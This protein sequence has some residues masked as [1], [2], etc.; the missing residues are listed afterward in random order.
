MAYISKEGEKYSKEGESKNKKHWKPLLKY[1]AVILISPDQD[2]S[3]GTDGLHEQV[4][5]LFC[6]CGVFG[7]DVVQIPD[8]KERKLRITN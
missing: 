3:D 4:P 8:R 1:R 2:L 5:V 7:Q 6:D